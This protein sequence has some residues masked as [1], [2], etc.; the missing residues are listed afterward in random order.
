MLDRPTF[1]N[2]SSFDSPRIISSICGRPG[3]ARSGRPVSTATGMG[4]GLIRRNRPIQVHLAFDA[5]PPGPVLS[6]SYRARQLI[7]D[8][9]VVLRS[10]QEH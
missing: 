2:W 6:L 4:P 7:G 9:T 5:S 8:E 10:S 3:L 1:P